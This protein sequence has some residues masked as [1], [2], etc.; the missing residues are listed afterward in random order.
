MAY[1]LFQNRHW[2][3]VVRGGFGIFYDLATSELGSQIQ[4]AFYPFGATAAFSGPGGGGTST[5][6]L[7]S[8]DAAP[9]AIT[10]PSPSNP[11]PVFGVDPHLQS[12]YTYEWNAAVEV[13][14][15]S[16]QSFSASY[17][18]AAGKQLLPTAVILS[19]PISFLQ[20][21]LVTNTGQS[22]Y[23]ALQLQFQRRLSRGLQ[24]LASYTWSHSI[25]TGSAGSIAVPA[26]QLV[27]GSVNAN[28]ASS[29]FDLRNAFSAGLTYNLPAPRINGVAGVVLRGWSTENFLLARSAPPV[30][31]SDLNFFSFNGALAS[32]RP[33]LVPGTPLYLYGSQYPGGKSLNQAAFTDP[34]TASTGCPF[35]CPA[36]QGN[37]S[38]NFLRGFGAT[39]WDFAVHRVFP[40]HE[41]LKLQFRAEMFNVLNHPNFGQPSGCFGLAC[42]QP[43]GVATVIL[44]QYLNGATIGSNVGGGALSP[45]YQLGGPRSIQLALKLEF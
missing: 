4:P 15:G 26:N 40:I 14:L 7:S 18:G 44:A 25:D 20:A 41:A 3:T 45:L 38:R 39:Q 8:S 23:N 13:A 32:I 1:Q 34:P 5:F 9:P 17:I 21:T 16:Q 37:T 30:N 31:V 12:P 24:A 11:Q 2:Q 28:R 33:D 36:R 22:N 19:P 42:T 35:A 6:P 10:A 43:F 29:D 27:P